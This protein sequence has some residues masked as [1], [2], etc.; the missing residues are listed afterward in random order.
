MEK[1]IEKKEA[2]VVITFVASEEEWKQAQNKEF[3]K[4]MANVSVPGFRKGHVPANIARARISPAQVMNDAMFALVNKDY[5]AALQEAGVTP[6]VQPQLNVTKVSDKELECS[7]TVALAPRV[8]LGEYKNL[9]VPAETAEIT[10]AEIEELIQKDLQNHAT[11]V[12]K[13]D[14][15]ALNDTV[16][17]DFKGYVDNVPFDGGEAKNYELKLG[18]NQFVPGFEDQLVGLKANDEKEITVTFP[19][20]YVKEL[21]GKEAKFEVKVHDVKT[22]VLPELNDEFVDELELTNVKGVDSYKA[23]VAYTAKL[24]RQR[25]LDNKRIDTIVNKIVDASKLFIAKQLLAEEAAA[26]IDQVKKQVEQSGLTYDDFLK[27]SNTTVEAFEQ[28]KEAEAERNIKTMLVIDAICNKENIVVD[29]AALN[30]KYEELAKQY[31]MKLEDVKKALE[32][33]KNQ[34]LSNL[35]NELFTK[36]I[37]SVNSGDAVE[38]PKAEEAKEVKP[39]AKKTTT[40]KKATTSEGTTAKKTTRKSTKKTT[41]EKQD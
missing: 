8:E 1:K 13:E 17:I 6:F 7:I 35:K 14:A 2:E 10:D 34:L 19:E 40:R 36:Y 30:R 22:T 37:L 38:A 11:L 27:L 18:S 24:N 12:L 20:N 26:S 28:M 15:A 32:P 5:A 29:S 21:A 9:N 31:S 16:V 25:E 41:E 39:A 33:Q 3:N 4:K 23:N